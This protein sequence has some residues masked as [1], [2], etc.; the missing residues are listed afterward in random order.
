MLEAKALIER[1]RVNY[2]TI[3]PHSALVYL[4]PAPET[5]PQHRPASAALKQSCAAG[6]SSM[7]SL[8]HE[9]VSFVGAGHTGKGQ[10]QVCFWFLLHLR[11]VT[12]SIARL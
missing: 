11:A 12:C 5:F 6:E 7:N 10:G 3:R 1:W 4:S 9:L 8:P 2:N